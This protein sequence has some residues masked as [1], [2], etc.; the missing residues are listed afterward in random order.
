MSLETVGTSSTAIAYLERNTPSLILV[1]I[2]LPDKDGLAL[3][4]QMKGIS[5]IKNVPIIILSA[6]TYSALNFKP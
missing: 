2:G 6:Y 5:R 4:K 3:L 1:D